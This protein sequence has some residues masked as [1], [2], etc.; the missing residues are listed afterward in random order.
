MNDHPLTEVIEHLAAA[1]AKV[2]EPHPELPETIRLNL[3]EQ[4][5]TLIVWCQ[6]IKGGGSD[7]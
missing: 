6:A 3:Q 5:E 4:F 2:D 1:L 7:G